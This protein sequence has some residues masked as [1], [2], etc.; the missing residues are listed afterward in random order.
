[1]NFLEC[2]AKYKINIEQA[3]DAPTDSIRVKAISHDHTRAWT[4]KYSMCELM[5]V[6]APGV[7]EEI[8]VE[9]LIKDM[10]LEEEN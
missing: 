2:A 7:Y 8:I 3:F 6:G 1:M 10:K 9:K 4:Q 5:F